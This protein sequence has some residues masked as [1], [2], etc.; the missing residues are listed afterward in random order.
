MRL[1]DGPRQLPQ[2]DDERHVALLPPPRW[3][4]EA[5]PGRTEEAGEQAPKEVGPTNGVSV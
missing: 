3:V 2:Q 1:A 4:D 5:R